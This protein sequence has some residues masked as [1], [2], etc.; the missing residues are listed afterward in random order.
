LLLGV[1]ESFIL[2]A[3]LILLTRWFTRKERSRANT[4]LLLGNP[5]TVLWMS[6][7]TGFLIRGIGWQE[8]FVIEGLISV[9]WAFGWLVLV[10]DDPTQALWMPESARKQLEAELAREQQALPAVIHL[11]AAFRH[12][13]VLRLCIHYFFWSLGVYGFVLWLPLVIKNASAQ[14][15]QVTGL[16]VA[17][18]YLAASILMLVVAHYSDR[19]M[20]R[21]RFIWPLLILSG[22]A[23]AASCLTLHSFA[24]AYGLL[25]LAGSTMYAPYGPFFAIVPEMLPKNVAGEIIALVNCCG[26]L[27]GFFGTWLV[28]L[29]QA[30]TGNPKAG[31]LLMAFSLVLGGLILA[32]MRQVPHEAAALRAASIEAR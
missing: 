3:M 21:K 4:I 10:K 11:R 19:S 14:A 6:A 22:A 26:A 13:N 30:Y 9:L 28:G 7:A 5:I 16:L 20:H 27:G 32:G 24:W 31:F 12:R 8:T 17:V 29:L 18:P 1:A 15:I 23:L 25:I 2:P